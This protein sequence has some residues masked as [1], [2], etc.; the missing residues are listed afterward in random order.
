MQA[1]GFIFSKV[2]KRYTVSKENVHMAGGATTEGKEKGEAD[3][4]SSTQTS[5]LDP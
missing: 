1:V 3:I 2:P 5:S 4:K